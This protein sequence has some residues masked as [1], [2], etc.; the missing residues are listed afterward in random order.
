MTEHLIDAGLEVHIW[1]RRPSTAAR[2]LAE[3]GALV[4]PTLPDLARRCKT[5]I[6]VLPTFD[7]VQ[8]VVSQLLPHLARGSLLIDSS[9]IDPAGWCQ[10]ATAASERGI[11][12]VDAP[13]TGGDV[14]AIAGTLTVMC[15]GEARDVE[16]AKRYLAC[17]S[18]DVLHVG[19]S[20]AG[21]VVK[22]ANQVQAA[23]SLLGMAEA[24]VLASKWGVDPSH[25]VHVLSRGAARCWA[26]ENRG[27]RVVER[28]FAPG[29]RVALHRKDLGIA[30]RI[31]EEVGV[32][33]PIAAQAREAYTSLVANGQ[34]DDDV[35]ALVNVYER[36]AQ[37][38]VQRG[39]EG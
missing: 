23:A 14:G 17:F 4:A 18:S 35:S 9:T 16:R 24:L 38:C 32:P 39:V 1:A 5:I 2:A 3:R 37:S 27:P 34:A 7:D 25:V 30:L 26:I 29:F 15:G 19:E 12:T 28:D 20:G 33:M 31:G 36:A 10:I 21:Q 13:V 8:M 11:A 22:A 6:T